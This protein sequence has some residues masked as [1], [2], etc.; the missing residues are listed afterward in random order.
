M[1][2]KR[3][4]R[5]TTTR[6]HWSATWMADET[7]RAAAR[8]P[9]PARNAAMSVPWTNMLNANTPPR[10]MMRKNT[11]VANELVFRIAFPSVLFCP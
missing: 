5:S 3:P 10:T 11:R 9:T 1:V 6:S 8:A 7:R 2:L 4:S